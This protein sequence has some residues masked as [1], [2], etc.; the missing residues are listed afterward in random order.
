VTEFTIKRHLSPLW[1]E[2]SDFL[3]HAVITDADDM[4][5][6]LWARRIKDNRFEV[7]CV[8]MFARNLALGDVVKTVEWSGFEHVVDAVVEPSGHYA[9][10]VWLGSVAEAVQQ[11]WHESFDEALTPTGCQIEIYSGALH[12]VDA[13]SYAAAASAVRWFQEWESRGIEWEAANE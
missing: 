13:P 1:E 9:Y 7:C 3:I 2:K 12:G 6:Q 8:P 5:E 4:L 10:R 11:Q